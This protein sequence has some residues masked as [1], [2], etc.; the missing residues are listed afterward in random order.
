MKAFLIKEPKRATSPGPRVPLRSLILQ[1]AE[2]AI[3]HVNGREKMMLQ[4]MLPLAKRQL[5]GYTDEQLEKMAREA[6][7]QLGAYLERAG[8]L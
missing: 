6:Y 1:A 7:R 2:E 8:V 5:D 4:A 3:S